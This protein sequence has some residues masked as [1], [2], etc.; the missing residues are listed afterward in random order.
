MDEI[1][2]FNL[3][4]R[5]LL[6]PEVAE[7]L[8]DGFSDTG[9]TCWATTDECL[10]EV[11]NS[12]VDRKISRVA[13]ATD[14]SV[15]GWACGA[16]LYDNFTWELEVL[17]VRRAKKNKGIGTA[18]LSDFEQRVIENGGLNVFLGT[19]DENGRTSLGEIDLY[20]DPLSHLGAIKNKGEHPFEF[21]KKQGYAISGVLP[22]A[23][24]KGKPDIFMTK[25][26]K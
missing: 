26:L 2:I 15:L 19:D 1:K 25:R 16:P 7:I 17:V 21:Y 13:V 10:K 6:I 14:E 18:L 20:P 22:D 9:T 23:N 5:R 12:L 3:D 8:R 24:G 4:D 11:E